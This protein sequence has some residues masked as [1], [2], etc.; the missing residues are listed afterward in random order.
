VLTDKYA[1]GYPGKRYYAGQQHYDTIET[2]AIER[3][4]AIF[5][6]EH[7]TT[8]HKTLR[9]PRGGLILCRA[10]HAKSIDQSVFPGLQGG[11]HMHAVAGVAVALKKAATAEFQEYCRQ[12]LLNAN[13][14][15]RELTRLGATLITGGTENHLMVV[16]VA[17]SYGIDGAAA[18]TQLEAAGII[19]NK[20]VIP[21]DAAPPMRPSGVRLGTPA[22][23]TR[24]MREPEMKQIATWIDR[25]LRTRFEI[26]IL[27]R[28][29]SEFCRGFPVPR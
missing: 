3:A 22:A 21:D 20:Q 9:G 13:S 8:T 10:A 29:V 17:K 19:C 26:K 14:L 11:P 24:G 5:G 4:K 6:A 25:I 16:D 2:I 15:A 18:Q 7:T 23:T 1:E 28:E 12:V 27:A